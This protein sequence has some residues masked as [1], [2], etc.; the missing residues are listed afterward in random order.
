MDSLHILRLW[1]AAAWADGKLHANEAAA[2]GRFIDAS[3][4]LDADQRREASQLLVTRP[5]VDVA[6]EVARL[7][8][9][10]RQGVYRAVL[11]IVRLDGEVS[12]AERAFLNRLRTM[13]QLDESTI[14]RIQTERR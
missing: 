6:A 2:L 12:D 3:A 8:A 1:A 5:D 7:D 9:S 13:L 10:A 4:D 11:G 14:G